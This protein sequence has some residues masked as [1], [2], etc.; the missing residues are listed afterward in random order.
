[1]EA[2]DRPQ[3]P[4]AGQRPPFPRVLRGSGGVHGNHDKS[5]SGWRERQRRGNIERR[6]ERS[7]APRAGAGLA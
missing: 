6:E 5:D 2:L 3:R 4:Q 7:G 1:M